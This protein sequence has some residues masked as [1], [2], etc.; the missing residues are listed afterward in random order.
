MVNLKGTT[1]LIAVVGT[2][3]QNSRMNPKKVWLVIRETFKLETKYKVIYCFGTGA[4]GMVCAVQD[5]EDIEDRL[6]S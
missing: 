4:Y 3:Y 5:T 1:L 2:E 6:S